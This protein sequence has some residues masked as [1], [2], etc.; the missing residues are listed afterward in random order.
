[1]LNEQKLQAQ[2]AHQRR[3]MLLSCACAV[4]TAGCCY[5]Q[6]ADGHCDRGH[7][8]EIALHPLLARAQ[9]TTVIDYET[10]VP[11]LRIPTQL[12]NQYLLFCC[13]ESPIPD[14]L[15]FRNKKFPYRWLQNINVTTTV[16]R[17]SNYLKQTNELQHTTLRYFHN[18]GTV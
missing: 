2:W 17:Y 9:A 6:H 3:S 16:N 13:Q 11:G 8:D 7:G 5:L 4:Y 12:L 15:L 10:R 1:M 18:T 14:Y